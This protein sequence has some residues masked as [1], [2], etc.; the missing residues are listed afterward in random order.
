MMIVFISGE[1]FVA[2][3]EGVWHNPVTSLAGVAP[4]R[5]TARR[6]P[7][8][9]QGLVQAQL[10]AVAASA[11]LCSTSISLNCRWSISAVFRSPGWVIVTVAAPTMAVNR[12]YEGDDRRNG[13]A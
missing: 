4:V 5:R 13:D 6:P 1:P 10:P 3:L 8:L 9:P 2:A 11:H 12:A 7:I